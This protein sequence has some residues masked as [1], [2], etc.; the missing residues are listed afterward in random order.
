MPLVVTKAG[1]IQILNALTG[2]WTG[3]FPVI[4]LFVNDYVPTVD[5]LLA[6]FTEASFPGY[7]GP[8][9]LAAWTFAGINLDG[10]AESGSDTKTFVS[11][12]G[13]PNETVHGYYV[14]WRGDVLFAERISPAKD[15]APPG[16]TLNLTLLFSIIS[17][18]V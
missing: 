11:A 16:A 12:G 5:S 7:P 2:I 10:A 6:D 18:F 17:K 8:Q 15:M 9:G 13:P 1:D 3:D 14:T 4:R